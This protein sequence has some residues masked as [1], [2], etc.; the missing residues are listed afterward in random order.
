MH[1]SSLWW[2]GGLGSKVLVSVHFSTFNCSFQVTEDKSGF[3]G[4]L[5]E[6]LEK[7]IFLCLVEI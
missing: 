6:R 3:M 7:Y 4:S 5:M 1:F 2:L